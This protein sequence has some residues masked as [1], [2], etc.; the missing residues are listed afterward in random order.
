MYIGLLLVLLL[1]LLLPLLVKKVEENLEIFLFIMGVIAVTISKTISIDF[2]LEV[3]ENHF[4]YMITA[5]VLI[6]GFLFRYV[7]KY[8]Q[9]LVEYILNHI[10][11]K[12]FISIMI[13][14]VGLVSSMI[15]AIIAALLL[16]EIIE[17]LP[18]SR[19]NKIKINIIACFSIGL[20]SILTPIGEP[21][22]TIIATKLDLD[23]WYMMT[24]LGLYII[25]AVV[26]LGVL[27]SFYGEKYADPLDDMKL[28]I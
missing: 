14:I 19:K 27:G 17:L 4:L 3:L 18:V 16:V 12:L 21:L 24:H 28:K 9:K 6:G 13:I 2:A 1:I 15:T 25:P 20:G 5:A 8:I 26:G 23:F 11:L 10:P 22:S 7:N